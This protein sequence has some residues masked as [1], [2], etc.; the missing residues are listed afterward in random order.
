MVSQ[1]VSA[2]KWRSA[3]AWTGFNF[4]TGRLVPMPLTTLPFT[5]HSIFGSD[6]AS[7]HPILKIVRLGSNPC[8][9]RVCYNPVR[10]VHNE[11]VG[12][13]RN[14]IQKIYTDPFTFCRMAVMCHSRIAVLVINFPRTR[15]F[16]TR[17]LGPRTAGS[18]TRA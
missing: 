1:S 17:S 10:C 15:F 18:R 8:I 11:Y 14:S 12:K 9:H 6:G 3:Q 16:H 4:I 2:D 13:V 7:A 5:G